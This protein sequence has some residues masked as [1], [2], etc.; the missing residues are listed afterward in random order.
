MM[1][2]AIFKYTAQESAQAR[3]RGGAMI[4]VMN[5]YRLVWKSTLTRT[6]KIDRYYSLV[7]A[8]ALWGIH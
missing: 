1:R 7:V 5:Q 4:Q 8:R 2:M 6:Q 3:R